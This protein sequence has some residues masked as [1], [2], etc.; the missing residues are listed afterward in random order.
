MLD[1]NS[2]KKIVIFVAILL[3]TIL[4]GV[5]LL[6][7]NNNKVEVEIGVTPKDSYLTLDGK[8]ISPG[9]Y[10]IEKGEHTLFA[11]HEFFED[12]TLVFNT[13]NT[14][15]SRPIYIA[16]FPGSPEAEEWLN[17]HNEDM[18]IWQIITGRKFDEQQEIADSRYP[19]LKYLPHSTIDWKIDYVLNEGGSA[20]FTITTFPYSDP[21]TADFDKQVETFNAEALEFLKNNGVDIEKEDI[22]YKTI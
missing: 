19:I 16:P 3:V 20:T 18:Q 11:K 4:V 9:K 14:D 15:T 5:V 13:N 22:A 2:R 7:M 21:G 6:M 1:L 10:K 17:T 8:Q 12:A